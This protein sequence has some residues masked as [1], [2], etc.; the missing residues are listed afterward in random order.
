[1]RNVANRQQCRWQAS[2]RRSLNLLTFFGPFLTLEILMKKLTFAA[3]FTVTSL[4][5]GLQQGEA[6]V[7]QVVTIEDP[8]TG[9]FIDN[10][11]ENGSELGFSLNSGNVF[12]AGEGGTTGSR[13]SRNSIFAFA[14]PDLTIGSTITG[15]ELD[16]SIATIQVRN[17]DED[18][19]QLVVSLL[20]VNSPTVADGLR[21]GLDVGAG[22]TLAATADINSLD[23]A[24]VF[25]AP[26]TL[27]LSAES[28][29]QFASFYNADGTANQQAFFR[30]SFEN[31]FDIGA[32]TPTRVDFVV[33]PG[34]DG[35]PNTL[36]TQ[37]RI[38]TE[39]ASVIPEPSS[40]LALGLLGV[41][42][43]TRRRKR[44]A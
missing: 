43:A 37:L 28:V 12:R 24:D 33:N 14:L 44:A 25:P 9:G 40:L 7:T 17:A 32:G 11:M 3:V 8:A 35:G 4:F 13:F 31:E 18:P 5:F 21:S 30:L 23:A 1:M 29:N 41:A 2:R 26:L 16:L 22:N 36:A 20:G 10:F 34:A 39:V 19:G 38:T 15:I 42:G 27:S 6:A